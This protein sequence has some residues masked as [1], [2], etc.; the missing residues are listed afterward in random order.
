MASYRE[1]AEMLYVPAIRHELVAQ[2]LYDKKDDYTEQNR[3]LADAEAIH[4]D[5]CRRAAGA[6][7]ERQ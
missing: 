4:A 6:L 5:A 7:L 1:I 2:A 3:I